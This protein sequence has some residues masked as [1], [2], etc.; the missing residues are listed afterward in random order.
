MDI[1]TQPGVLSTGALS[2][3]KELMEAMDIICS[4]WSEIKLL[5]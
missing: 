4:W 3:V 5:K 2:M 1:G